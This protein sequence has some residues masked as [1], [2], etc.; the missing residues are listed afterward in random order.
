MERRPFFKTDGQ[1]NKQQVT[2]G[3]EEFFE[4]ED[5]F[6]AAGITD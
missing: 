1:I 3:F 4:E 5:T 2:I 6:Y